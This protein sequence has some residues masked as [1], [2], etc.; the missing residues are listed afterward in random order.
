MT[1]LLYILPFVFVL[2]LIGAFFVE[3]GSPKGKI[4]FIIMLLFGVAILAMNITSAFMTISETSALEA[5]LAQIENW[6]TGQINRTNT[7]LASMSDKTRSEGEKIAALAKFG[8]SAHNPAIKEAQLADTARTELTEYVPAPVHFSTIENLPDNVDKMLVSFALEELGFIVKASQ[9]QSEYEDKAAGDTDEENEDED[10]DEEDMEDDE[11]KAQQDI[12]EKKPT[13]VLYFG[14][15]V[16][17]NDIKLILY[18]LLRAG[19]QIRMVKVH[20]KKSDKNARS[21]RF[22]YSRSYAKR[23]PYTVEKIKKLKKFKR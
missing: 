2:L 10:E 19:I 20:K 3:L 13:N 4:I 14:H 17:N 11:E 5:K 9:V 18:T 7:I 22:D 12:V 1:L 6:K 16:R 23:A 21:V 15:L 8:W